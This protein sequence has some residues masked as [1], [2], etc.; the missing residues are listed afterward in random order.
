MMTHCVLKMIYTSKPGFFSTFFSA[1]GYIQSYSCCQGEPNSDGCQVHTCHV[2]D[3]LDYNDMRGF[4]ATLNKSSTAPKGDFGIFALDC[5]MCNTTQGNE[6][7]RVT[8]V[9]LAGK[10]VY[11]TLVKPDNDVID[12]N[13]RY[14]KKFHLKR[15]PILSKS[16]NFRFSGITCE[17]LV[18]VKTTIRDVQAVL[19]SM[20][21]D[22]TILIGHSLES[23][24][25]ALKVRRN[26]KLNFVNKV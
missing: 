16:C 3:V 10:T 22:K 12:H 11:E 20:F 25:K 14:N 15:K 18:G 23:D 21:S 26:P 2:T 6:L 19:L 24:L 9:N 8:V 7:T 4:V 17:D 1:T 5:E 13:T